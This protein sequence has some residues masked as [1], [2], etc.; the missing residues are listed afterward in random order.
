[1]NQAEIHGFLYDFFT[2]RQADILHNEDGLLKVK[3]TKELDQKLMNRPFYWQYIQAMGKEG[4]PLSV[5]FQSKE[6][7]SE[8]GE[9]VHF[10]SPRLQQ[11]FDII[12]EEGKYTTLY[13]QLEEKT[14]RTPLYPWFVCNLQVKYRGWYVHDELVSLG[15]LLT[16][17]TMR[18]NWME[19]N[20]HEE[21]SETIPDYAYTIPLIIS[22]QRAMEQITYELSKRIKEDSQNFYDQ[23]VALYEKEIQMLD[24]LTDLNDEES[25]NF[26]EQNKEQIY[27]RL[28]PKVELNW[29]NGGIF[30]LSKDKT[31]QLTSI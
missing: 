13:E 1:M 29:V 12:K 7:T 21:Y 5:T 15:I 26:Y 8:E 20:M 17:G 4:E 23:S 27:E 2:K 6:N 18:F 22:P 24:D 3:L 11:I 28:Y 10:G 14:N 19:E 30:Y 25:Q 9:W 31:N 16:N